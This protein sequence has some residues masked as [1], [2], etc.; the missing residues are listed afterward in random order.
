[1]LLG[2]L[3]VPRLPI[4]SFMVRHPPT[5]LFIHYNFV[6]AL[7]N[8]MFGIQARGGC[9]CAGPYAQVRTV[10]NGGGI[11]QLLSCLPLILGTR[12][13]NLVGA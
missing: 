3:K 8:D 7:L 11:A 12:I 2:N 9:A 10:P 6:C 4:F 13:R 1:M 5:G